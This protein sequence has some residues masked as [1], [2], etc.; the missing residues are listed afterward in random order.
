MNTAIAERAAFAALRRLL[1]LNRIW[2][3]CVADQIR[4]GAT[5]VQKLDYTVLA[6]RE[7]GNPHCKFVRN[8]RIERAF[9]AQEIARAGFRDQITAIVALRFFG[10]QFDRAADGVLAVQRALRSAQD[11]SPLKIDQLQEQTK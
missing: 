6:F 4:I 8:R 1:V 11:F 3:R 7:R 5:E 10:N 2:R 9:E